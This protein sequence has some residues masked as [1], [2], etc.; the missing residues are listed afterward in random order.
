MLPRLYWIGLILNVAFQ[1]LIRSLDLFLCAR[2]VL[3]VILYS[4]IAQDML[5]R[6]HSP[7]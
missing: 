7:Q 1:N 3:Y 6:S 2:I 4:P 5:G